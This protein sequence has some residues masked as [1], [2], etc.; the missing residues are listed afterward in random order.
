MLTV[1]LLPPLQVDP[2]IEL[3]SRNGW[4]TRQCEAAKRPLSLPSETEWQLIQLH[5]EI[6]TGIPLLLLWL[7]LG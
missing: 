7:R 5:F 2:F 1:Y 3:G 4:R 6:G